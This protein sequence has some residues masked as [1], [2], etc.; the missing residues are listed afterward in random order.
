MFPGTWLPGSTRSLDHPNGAIALAIAENR[1]SSREFQEALEQ[2][3]SCIPLSA[4]SYQDMRGIPE[5]RAAIA[6]MMQTTFMQG[7]Q[8]DPDNLSVLAGCG[9]VVDMLFHL[10]ADEG[11]SILIPAPYYPAFDNDL[12]IR[13]TLVT[14]PVHLDYSDTDFSAV[15]DA[16]ATEAR[17]AGRPVKGLLLTNPTNPQGMLYSRPQLHC[18]MQWCLRNEVHFISS[19]KLLNTALGNLGYF[20]AVSGPL[21]WQLT[22]LLSDEAWLHNFL[23]ENKRR[24]QHVYCTLSSGLT[25]AG[26]PFA[27]ARAA[28]FLWADLSAAFS[29]HSSRQTSCSDENEATWEDEARFWEYM[30][31]QHKV[32]LTPGHACH[33]ARPGW[34]RICY[35]W[36][37]PDCI[38]TVVE[39]IAAAVK[40]FQQLQA[41]QIS[42]SQH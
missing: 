24:L 23:A 35:A 11:Q 15:L 27:P 2:H 12:K 25:A 41:Q 37:A 9:T 20:A 31:K 38:P 28:M 8:V 18:C 3:S 17:Q 42:E 19:N 36:P 29:T 39:R 13:N 30:V 4:M 16:A 5:L 7:V 22:R 14:V 10:I 34:F 21:Q 40:G 6:R 32:V 1:L 26:I 33:A